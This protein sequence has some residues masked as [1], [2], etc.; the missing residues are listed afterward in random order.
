MNPQHP[1]LQAQDSNRGA[2]GSGQPLRIDV[3]HHIAPP[4]YLEELAPMK[5][6]TPQTVNWTVQKTLDQMDEAGV[7]LSITSV[8]TPSPQVR[9]LTSLKVRPVPNCAGICIGRC[10]RVGDSG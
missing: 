5:R 7:A 10:T 9:A 8:T 2:G 6:L 4:A 3:H 1:L